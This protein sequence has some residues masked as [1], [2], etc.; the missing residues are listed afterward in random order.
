MGMTLTGVRLLECTLEILRKHHDYSSSCKNTEELNGSLAL[1]DKGA[2]EPINSSD[3]CLAGLLSNVQLVDE[4]ELLRDQFSV[5]QLDCESDRK[6]IRDIVLGCVRWKKLLN[7]TLKAFFVE[8]GCR[9]LKADY[10]LFAV[11]FY[12]FIFKL[13]EFPPKALAEVLAA[14]D[15]TKMY[16]MLQFLFDKTHMRETLRPIWISML[17]ESFT[18]ETLIKP[19]MEMRVHAEDHLK[20]L[21]QRVQSGEQEQSSKKKLTEPVP[22]LLTK[23][24]PRKLPE[25][26]D[27]GSLVHT[28]LPVPQSADK[29]S[30]D[31]L[32]LAEKHAKNYQAAVEGQR[33]AEKSLFKVAK[34][35]RFSQ[36]TLE[37][38]EK[39]S[40]DKEA[41]FNTFKAKPIMKDSPLK[42]G[43]GSSNAQGESEI[44]KINT[45]TIL[46][47]DAL[48][49]KEMEKK[50]QEL[51]KVELGLR[52]AT[53]YWKWK[54]EL[55]EKG[56]Y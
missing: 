40:K 55:D 37:K 25:P 41:L 7:L 32:V 36:K 35:P 56:M 2:L 22:F 14:Q 12:L 24:H 3:R 43:E 8:T 4:E 51:R 47:E 6:L 46:R 33:E 52:D 45:A 10:N 9:Y 30:V 21:R 17:D 44:V 29:P 50:E 31:L 19:I 26:V 34:V 39:F 38:L 18:D 54:H 48:I 28:A 5:M 13:S 11:L 23:P 27:R 16:K 20:R 42:G 15:A 49:R 1:R 53:D